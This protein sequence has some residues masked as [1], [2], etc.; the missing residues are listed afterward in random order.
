MNDQTKTSVETA[1][2]NHVESGDLL[3][4]RCGAKP[5]LTRI[6]TPMGMRSGIKLIEIKCRKYGIGVGGYGEEEIVKMWQQANAPLQASG[7]DDAR[8]TK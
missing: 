2:R 8:K 1:Q 3:A 6:N 4:C 7:A 5:I